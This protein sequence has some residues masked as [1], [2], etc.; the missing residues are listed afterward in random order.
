[1]SD[2][3]ASTLRVPYTQAEGLWAFVTLPPHY[4]WQYLSLRT[5]FPLRY[6]VCDQTVSIWREPNINVMV[7]AKVLRFSQFPYR[8]SSRTT[9][10]ILRPPAYMLNELSNINL[11]KSRMNAFPETI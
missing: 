5:R 11:Y 4:T 2:P 1:M 9:C 6:S 7:R 3:L 10:R 8:E